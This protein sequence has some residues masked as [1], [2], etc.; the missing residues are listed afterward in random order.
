[1]PPA[2]GAISC[3]ASMHR[4]A[5]P[6]ANDYTSI[7][8]REARVQLGCRP[9]RL[10]VHTAIA[11]RHQA[12]RLPVRWRSRARLSACRIS[13]SNLR[14]CKERRRALGAGP[15]SAP[16]TIAIVPRVRHSACSW[17][18]ASWSRPAACARR[19]SLRGDQLR[20]DAAAFRLHDL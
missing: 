9:L 18:S 4:S 7:A 8:C 11:A 3:N 12:I 17:P 16:A 2:A 14:N 19:R 5:M 20:R 15:Y 13:P 10:A 1:M 6:V